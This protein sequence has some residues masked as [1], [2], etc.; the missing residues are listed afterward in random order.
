M[1][2]KPGVRRPLVI[3]MS[4][5]MVPVIHIRTN[6]RTAGMDR[7]TYFRLLDETT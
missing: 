6:M 1:M 3:K 5:R 4:P 2:T 7:E